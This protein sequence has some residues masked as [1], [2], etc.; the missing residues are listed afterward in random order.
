MRPDARDFDTDDDD[1]DWEWEEEEDTELPAHENV[2]VGSSAGASPALT[3][4]PQPPVVA[5]QYQRPPR[6]AWRWW[7]VLPVAVA[8]GGA[9]YLVAAMFLGMVTNRMGLEGA[10]QSLIAHVPAAF[11]FGYYFVYSGARFAPRSQLRVLFSLGGVI[12][13]IG[14]ILFLAAL[15][16]EIPWG[17]L[18]PSAMA[19]AAVVVWRLRAVDA[20]TIPEFM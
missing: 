10:T 3:E 20:D 16:S 1:D 9:A 5:A 14:P 7:G 19:G 13:A 12:W 17:V 6:S 4:P 2:S 15:S 8:A 18:S 11:A